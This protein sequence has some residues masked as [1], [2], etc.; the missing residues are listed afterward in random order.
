M[1]NGQMPAWLAVLLVLAGGGLLA[2]SHFAFWRKLRH[3]R[4]LVDTP[5]SKARGVFVGYVEVKGSALCGNPLRAPLSRQECVQFSWSVAEHYRR[6]KT[7]R[8]SK[9]RT[10]TRVESGW[11]QV[12]AETSAVLFDVQ[13]ETG[14]VQVRPEGA[15][16]EGVA[17]FERTC[18]ISD[19]LYYGMGPAGGVSGSTGQRRFAETAVPTGSPVFVTGQ[20]R[21]RSDIVAAE[22]AKPE[23]DEPFRISIRTEEQIGG[24]LVRWMFFFACSSAA[25]SGLALVLLAAMFLGTL[26]S[27]AGWMAFALGCLLS[28]LT[29]SAGSVL[30]LYNSLI[31]LRNRVARA[32]T[33]VDVELQ[34]RHDLI[35][36]LAEAVRGMAG[37]EQ[38]LQREA[39]RLRSLPD[40]D[41][42]SGLLALS[43]SYPDLKSDSLFQSLHRELTNTEDRIALARNY[44]VEIASFY[45]TRLQAIPDTWIARLAGCRQ[46]PLAL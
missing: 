22:I 4:L 21:E 33:L 23:E 17:T 34:R 41:A 6:T 12:H 16:I 36:R 19:P 1:V 43:E 10:Q 26:A 13:D 35:P 3:H 42:G 32:K 5:C 18:G 24:S 31:S 15:E 40:R 27:A 29:L 30:T 8:D 45:N 44:Y 46:A 9:G 37:H 20:A 28:G 39:A 25:G 14:A 7:Y 2:L 38:E 11:E